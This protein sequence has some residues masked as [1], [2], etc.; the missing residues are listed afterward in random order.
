VHEPVG[1]INRARA[2]VY[3]SLQR[4]RKAKSMKTGKTDEEI[5]KTLIEVVSKELDVPFEEIT[6]DSSLADLA[7]SSV[8]AFGIHEIIES[9]LEVPFPPS[10][11]FE[12]SNLRILSE[13]L[14]RVSDS[15]YPLTKQPSPSNNHQ[16]FPS[17]AINEVLPFVLTG[18]DGDY[19]IWSRLMPYL[20]GQQFRFLNYCDI[21]PD[22]K[23]LQSLDE[24][25][26]EM[27]N[28]LVEM[29]PKGP[30]LIIAYSFGGLI[31]TCMGDHIYRKTGCVPEVTLIDPRF[32]LNTSDING[33]PVSFVYLF[34]AVLLSLPPLP[35]PRMPPSRSK[36]FSAFLDE[37]V[38]LIQPHV[39]ADIMPYIKTVSTTLYRN[40]FCS[41]EHVPKFS[42]AISVSFIWAELIESPILD[43]F[44]NADHPPSSED[45]KKIAKNCF[46]NAQVSEQ[47]I[48]GA[49][50]SFFVVGTNMDQLAEVLRKTINDSQFS[51]KEERMASAS[52]VRV[53][54]QVD[55]DGVPIYILHLQ[56]SPNSTQTGYEN[57]L[58]YKFIADFMKALDE[59]V[60]DSKGGPAAMITVGK[61][62]HYSYGFDLS[63]MLE[64]ETIEERIKFFKA[65]ELL[66]LRILTFP[67][68]TLAAINGHV[69]LLVECC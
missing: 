23:P 34:F 40:M 12:A 13:K 68:I 36:S 35:K 57:R 53:E 69:F 15:Q 9:A 33:D 16:I 25:A 58:N 2:Y 38:E 32:D 18:I 45:Y 59:V 11:L 31:A 41:I 3:S 17:T 64:F 55:G 10:L 28:T 21:S 54:R 47:I 61:R 39:K 7:M 56:G 43:L 48:N 20:D 49:N 26:V 46:P 65:V 60:K 62:K 27:T 29:Q 42:S 14:S 30:Y 37:I 63:Q 44:K 22:V 50:H 8:S 1:A 52:T 6:A 67:M 5:L 66:F 19:S 51:R 4:A 24:V